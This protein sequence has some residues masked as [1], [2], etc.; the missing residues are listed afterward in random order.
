MQLDQLAIFAVSTDFLNEILTKLLRFRRFAGVSLTAFRDMIRPFNSPLITPG[1]N[2][3]DLR[4]RLFSLFPAHYFHVEETFH[5]RSCPFMQPAPS[6]L[7]GCDASVNE[8]PYLRTEELYVEILERNHWVF[9]CFMENIAAAI[10]FPRENRTRHFAPRYYVRTENWFSAQLGWLFSRIKEWSSSLSRNKCRPRHFLNYLLNRIL[11]TCYICVLY[12]RCIISRYNIV[13]D[14]LS[15]NY[16][17]S[18]F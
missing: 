13:Y 8:W 16:I 11:Y 9:Q 12:I 14:I 6:T 17:L 4:P 3:S 2:S 15:G 7:H 5:K 10:Y 18:N 1:R